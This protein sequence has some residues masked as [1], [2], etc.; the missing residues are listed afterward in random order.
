MLLCCRVAVIPALQVF[1]S[2]QHPLLDGF[3]RVRH[4]HLQRWDRQHSLVNII[5]DTITQLQ[6]SASATTTAPAGFRPAVPSPQLYGTQ[7]TAAA[8][9]AGY[10]PLG[11]ASP[12]VM[13]APATA[14]MQQPSPSY[15]AY[16]PAGGYPAMQPTTTYPVA[17][18]PP[19]PSYTA[20][21]GGQTPDARLQPMPQALPLGRQYSDKIG[22]IIPQSFPELERMSDIQLRRL[23]ED[24]IAMKTHLAQMQE[25]KDMR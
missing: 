6:S 12:S 10:P 24:D 18:E 5:Q 19:P 14:A 16:P 21:V 22:T 4:P 9:A 2:I 25:V 11:V 7:P 15:A 13:G 23:L 3:K 8:A 17:R 1:G 20:V